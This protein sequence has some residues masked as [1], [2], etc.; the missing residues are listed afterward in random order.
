MPNDTQYPFDSWCWLDNARAV[1]VLK[2]DTI[3]YVG[4]D[5][6]IQSQAKIPQNLLAGDCR[7]VFG[8][9]YFL[10]L[11]TDWGNTGSFCTGAF[12][13]GGQW[14][15][16]NGSVHLR[17][18]TPVA[19]LPT[20]TLS[21]DDQISIDGT[22]TPYSVYDVNYET[23][24]QAVWINDNCIAFKGH[25]RLFFYQP[26]SNTLV[27]AD[28]FSDIIPN[29]KEAVYYGLEN[30]IPFKDGCLYSAHDIPGRANIE[31]HIYY[32]DVN[33]GHKDLFNGAT[34]G[35][36]FGIS[37]LAFMQTYIDN[38]AGQTDKT[39]LAFIAEDQP[40]GEIPS[41][42]GWAFYRQAFNTSEYRRLIYEGTPSNQTTFY[43]YDTGSNGTNLLSTYTPDIK[44]LFQ[45][46][47]IT[48]RG[49]PGNLEY[50][51]S[52][53]NEQD[54]SRFES[55]YLYSEKTGQV[56]TL[57]NYIRRWNDENLFSSPTHYINFIPADSYDPTHLKISLIE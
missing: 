12:E 13:L 27:L 31:C 30:V 38:T 19:V 43:V 1:A 44:D 20:L 16:Y 3:S 6:Q 9:R 2:G 42:D 51:F 46:E 15:L 53:R 28:D 35:N 56:T 23:F 8:E 36:M 40:L 24:T 18:G 50:I 14:Q 10:L 26:D 48:V 47:L 7:P 52:A 25:S 57:P 21:E 41:V 32:G 22:M 4:L 49:N 45:Y 39:E 5:N 34:F 37:G 33:G 54:D 55:S 17:D 29:T 11:H